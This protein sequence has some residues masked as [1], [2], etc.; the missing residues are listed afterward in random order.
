MFQIVIEGNDAAKFNLAHKDFLLQGKRG[1]V[2]GR[3][4]GYSRKAKHKGKEEW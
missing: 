1:K 2:I 4:K 3:S